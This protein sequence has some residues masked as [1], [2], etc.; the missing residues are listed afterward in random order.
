MQDNFIK[1][2]ELEYLKGI[3]A[4][5]ISGSGQI[6]NKWLEYLKGCRT[7]NLS[8]CINITDKGL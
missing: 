1:D 7:I 5:N 6:T 8:Y 3:R 4:I 2:K